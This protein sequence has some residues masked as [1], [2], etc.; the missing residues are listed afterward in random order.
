MGAAFEILRTDNGPE[1]LS[2]QFQ[3]W[4][5]EQKITWQR[6][7]RYVHEEIGHVERRWGMLVPMARTMLLRAN[8]EKRFWAD[9][10]MYS[11]WIWNRTPDTVHGEETACTGA[12]STPHERMYSKRP[13][14]SKARIFGCKAWAYLDK[15]ERDSK[16]HEVSVE[17]R[18]V[19]MEPNLSLIHI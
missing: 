16:M 9:A 18:F 7:T 17:G 15:E 11:A 13:N 3:M 6:S 12:A 4:L 14:L 19:G 2:D 10:M 1:M 5:A 8:M